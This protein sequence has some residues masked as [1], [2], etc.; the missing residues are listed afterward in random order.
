MMSISI[1]AKLSDRTEGIAAIFSR[2][3]TCNPQPE[4]AITVIIKFVSGA[5]HA[6]RIKINCCA[7]PP[8][9]SLGR[10]SPKS[11]SIYI[12]YT[13]MYT[14]IYLYIRGIP[15]LPRQSQKYPDA[16]TELTLYIYRALCR[17]FYSFSMSRGQ[18]DSL[19]LSRVTR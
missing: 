2:N 15:E 13:Y 9:E 11:A 19:S 1:G 4:C 16:N 12:L 10:A 18:L 3:V 5:M 17:R 14:Y 6:A 7:V 8:I